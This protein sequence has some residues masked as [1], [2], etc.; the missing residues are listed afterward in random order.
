MLW[1][2]QFPLLFDSKSWQESKERRQ[3]LPV[4]KH[5]CD[6]SSLCSPLEQNP[7]ANG[8]DWSVRVLALQQTIFHA[9][10]VKGLAGVKCVFISRVTSDWFTS[11]AA[12]DDGSISSREVKPRVPLIN[13][14]KRSF[15]LAPT[16]S[17]CICRKSSLTYRM[18][19]ATSYT[20]IS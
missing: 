16:P 6:T 1:I 10:R 3:Y 12:G 17:I 11:A 5:C 4:L 19:A 9:G 2:Y 18:E 20:Y 13:A 8:S 15:H 7:H 14:W